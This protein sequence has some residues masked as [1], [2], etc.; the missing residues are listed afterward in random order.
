MRR[1]D[2]F[3]AGLNR[4]QGSEA[5]KIRP[6][7]LVARNDALAAVERYRRGVVSVV[8]MTSNVQVRGLMH[9][10]IRPSARNGLRTASKAQAEQVR[11][12]DLSRLGRHVGHLGRRDLAAV[13]AA[14]RHH[15]AL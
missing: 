4:V 14:L 7:V 12:V 11:S 6:V 2:I 13:D 10:V 9:V 5:N 15:L 3:L 8:P 1:G